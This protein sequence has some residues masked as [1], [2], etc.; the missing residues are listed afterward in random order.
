MK[1]YYIWDMRNMWMKLLQREEAK[2]PTM[3][4]KN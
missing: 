2:N 1:H 4:S 3:I